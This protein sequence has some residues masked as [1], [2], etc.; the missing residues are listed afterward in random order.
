MSCLILEALLDLQES[1]TIQLSN[2][3]H[4]EGI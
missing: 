1:L 3:L 4:A 2:W